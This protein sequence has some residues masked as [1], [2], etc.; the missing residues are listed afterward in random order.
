MKKTTWG[1]DGNVEALLK[2][3]LGLDE[4]ER[5]GGR[6]REGE[7]KGEGRGRRRGEVGGCY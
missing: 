4:R 3:S 1:G 5:G 6:G 2:E 7:K